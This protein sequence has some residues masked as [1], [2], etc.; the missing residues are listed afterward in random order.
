MQ[1]SLSSSIAKGGT[2]QGIH[3]SYDLID[4][5]KVALVVASC[6]ERKKAKNLTRWILKW[7]QIGTNSKAGDYKDD[8][9][10]STFEHYYD[11]TRQKN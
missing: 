7:N 4:P 1:I 3:F 9:E 5:M 2:K 8:P 10:T 11:D 6:P